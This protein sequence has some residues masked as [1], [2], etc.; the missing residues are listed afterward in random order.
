[1]STT[2]Q[3]KGQ[4]EQQDDLY[5]Q[6]TEELIHISEQIGQHFRQAGVARQYSGTAGRR[7]NSQIGVFLLYAA[8]RG[9]AFLDRALYLPEEWTSD[10]VRCRQAGIADEVTFATK[11]ELAR[12]MLARAFAAGV[13]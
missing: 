2:K 12:Q 6:E 3:E 11:G 10:R 7:E 1:M 4:P 5:Q 9:A 8:N 13:R